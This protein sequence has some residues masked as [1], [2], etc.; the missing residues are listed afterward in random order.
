[1]GNAAF[2]TA[3][4]VDAGLAGGNHVERRH[5]R[6]FL[7]IGALIGVDSFHC[8]GTKYRTKRQEPVESN[9]KTKSNVTVKS[10]RR[11]FF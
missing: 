5:F 6:D 4:D 2:S 10:T 7:F 1:M 11:N 9:A 3:L 8:A